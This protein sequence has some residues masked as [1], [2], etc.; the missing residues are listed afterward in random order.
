[1]KK[2]T[3]QKKKW[4]K[5][6]KKKKNKLCRLAIKGDLLEWKDS[7]GLYGLGGWEA[8]ASSQMSPGA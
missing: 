4:K 7:W 5:K 1:M 3:K 8:S 6:Q 2:N